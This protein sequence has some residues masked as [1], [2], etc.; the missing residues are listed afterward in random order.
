M[1][2]GAGRRFDAQ[3]IGFGTP[4]LE[5]APTCLPRQS[6]RPDERPHDDRP[7]LG[8]LRKWSSDSQGRFALQRIRSHSV[9]RF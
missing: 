9:N 4:M 5:S 8:L 3:T 6:S 1:R 7:L 2:E